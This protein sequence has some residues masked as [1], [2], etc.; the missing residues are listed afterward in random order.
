MKKVYRLTKSQDFKKVL[1]QRHCAGK[2][3]SFSVFYAP[4]QVDHARIGLSVSTKIGNAV[5]RARV[6]RQLRAQIN[7]L[8]IL[9]SPIDV[10]IIAHSGYLSKTFQENTAVLGKVF[11]RLGVPSKEEK[12]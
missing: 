3:Q 1:D 8:D 10:V 7:L 2:N 12:A 5:V 6:R 11:S 4:N 9:E